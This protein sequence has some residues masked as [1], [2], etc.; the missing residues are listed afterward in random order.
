MGAATSSKINSKPNRLNLLFNIRKFF[1]PQVFQLYQVDAQ[2]KPSVLDYLQVRFKP[3]VEWYEKNALSNM[4]RFYFCQI[5]IVIVGAAIP[6]LNLF[7][8]IGFTSDIVIRIWSSVLG[9]TIIILTGF[10]QLTKAHESWILYRSTVES[11]KR[12][13][14]L[15]ALDTGEYSEERDLELKGK[16]FIRRV[17]SIIAAE[18]TKF[19]ASRDSRN[20]KQ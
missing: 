19:L 5:I 8:P 20:Q 16:L 3:Q 14:H 17:E 7:G 12:E 10:L 15:F 9:S 6:I 13:Y 18:G 2:H 4:Q 1:Q 11:L